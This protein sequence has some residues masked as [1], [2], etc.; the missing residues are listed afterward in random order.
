MIGIYKITNRLN[1]KSYVGQ[2]IHIERRWSEHMRPSTD[3][4]ISRAIKKCGKENFDFQVLCE[5]LEEDLNSLEEYYIKKY[6]TVVPDGYNV[7]KSD[8]STR[9]HFTLYMPE[10]LETIISEIINTDT[11]FSIIARKHNLSRRTI[12]RINKGDVHNHPELQY[13]LRDTKFNTK[14][15]TPICAIC[16]AVKTRG[17]EL[18]SACARVNS[19][20]VIERPS[21]TKLM[22][23]LMQKSFE[24]VGL[25]YG[26][27]PETIRK[28]CRECGI[29]TSRQKIKALYISRGA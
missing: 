25:Q 29:P 16:G 19:R 15:E 21:A 12:I 11:P 26:V 22:E 10:E 6:N 9:T 18:C 24:D 3:S 17:A 13:P 5:C 4:L 8:G 27:N 1:G 23:L 7:L 2:S 20:K 14:G 28:W